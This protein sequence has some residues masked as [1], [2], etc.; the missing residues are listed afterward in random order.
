MADSWLT[1]LRRT[2][3]RVRHNTAQQ[4]RG[5]R[6]LRRYGVAYYNWWPQAQAVP[7]TW[8]YRFLQRPRL[9][10]ATARR[11]TGFYS[12]F[13][14]RALYPYL[15]ADRKVFFTGEN[16]AHYPAYR[17]Y[18]APSTDL[19]L[20]FAPASA[21]PNY[22]RFPLWLL[23]CFP[24]E[25]TLADLTAT[26]E[27]QNRP[28][29]NERQWAAALVARHD[30]GGQRRAI[31]AATEPAVPVAYGGAFGNPDGTT[32][33]PGWPAKHAY[34]RQFRFNVCPENSAAPGYCTEKLFQ[35][36]AAGCRPVYWGHSPDPEPGILNPKF[37]LWYDPAHPNRLTHRLHQL[38]ADAGA[39][40]VW[41][42]QAPYVA[43]AAER[44][45]GF[46][47]RL[48]ERLLDG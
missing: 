17:D 29:T 7:Q 14:P 3:H 36:I 18:G 48:E 30:R 2:Q 33:A 44:I 19:A 22:L 25:A 43:G 13:G 28:P 15:P 24:P 40:G 21:H 37:L 6:A 42:G 23:E 45:Y 47:E 9:R 1:R 38:G 10:D 16:L 4:W 8:F 46:Y 20:G 12:V 5:W 27:R 39:E 32:L 41:E 26:V 31:A 34:L 35:A 11:R